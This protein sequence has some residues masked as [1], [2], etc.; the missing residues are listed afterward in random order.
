LWLAADELAERIRTLGHESPGSYRQFAALTQIPEAD[1]VPK[2]M[3]MVADLAA[4]NEAV[5]RA[6]GTAFHVA[7][8]AGDQAT[9]DIATQRQQ[10]HEK[11]AWMLRSMLE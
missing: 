8:A 3:E 6:A 11:S 2:A 4:G 7:D 1:G 5:G 9:A 10:V